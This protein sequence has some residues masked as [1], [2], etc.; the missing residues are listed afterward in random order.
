MRG[1]VKAQGERVVAQVDGRQVG[2]GGEH[3]DRGGRVGQAVARG[4]EALEAGDR[5]ER[6][7]VGEGVA[8]EVEDPEVGQREAEVGGERRQ[9]AVCE[10][11]QLQVEQIRR[12][13]E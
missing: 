7:E 9:A 1:G 3:V 5:A 8:V 10:L 2:E 13:G 11:E 4:E 6:R 12:R